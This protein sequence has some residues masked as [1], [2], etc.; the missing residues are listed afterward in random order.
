MA[1]KCNSGETEPKEPRFVT[2]CTQN[3]FPFSADSWLAKT[4]PDL[5]MYFVAN[6]ASY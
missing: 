3:K 2:N 1:T 5:K 4:F 6:S